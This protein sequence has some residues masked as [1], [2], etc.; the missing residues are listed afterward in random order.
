MK[1]YTP[2]PSVWHAPDIQVA[3]AEHERLVHWVVRRQ[4]LGHLSYVEALHA[5]RMGLWQALQRYDPGHG[6]TLS[7]YAVP[8]I[9]RAVWRAVAQTQPDPQEL[10]TAHPPQV[11]DDPQTCADATLIREALAR[12]VAALPVRLRAVVVTRYGLAGDA[13]QTFAAI[14]Q[15]L[16]VTRQRVQ[17]LHA[18]LSPACAGRADRS[19]RCCGWLTRPIPCS[20]ANSSTATRPPTIRLTSPACAAGLSAC[21]AQA[22]YAPPAAGRGNR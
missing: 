15:A 9:T 1:Q 14:A 13:P 20:C 7:T 21:D 12:L 8:A 17:Q 2:F 6:T 11:A 5:G 19:R 3:L 18:C 22:D 4:W 16:G 10:L